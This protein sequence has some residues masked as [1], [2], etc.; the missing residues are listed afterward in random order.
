MLEDFYTRGQKDA[1]VMDL[2]FSI[3]ASSG[4]EGAVERVKALMAHPDYTLKNPNRMR[5]VLGAFAG[6]N[7][8]GFHAST[9]AGYSLLA[10]TIIKLDRFNPQMAA[11]ML[12]PLTR[13]RKYDALRRELMKAALEKIQAQ[14]EL[15]PD[16]FEVVGKSLSDA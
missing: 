6:Q 2:W 7:V 10:D 12:G 1:L 8:S 11:R 16:V 5:S 4:R 14:A 13:W 15:S 3:Q 9:G